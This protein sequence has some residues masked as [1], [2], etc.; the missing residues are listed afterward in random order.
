MTQQSS[1]LSFVHINRKVLH[2]DLL[3]TP[4]NENFP[5]VLNLHCRPVFVAVVTIFLHD[6][7]INFLHV[8]W[9]C[10]LFF[11]SCSFFVII[12]TSLLTTTPKPGQAGKV[13]RPLGSKLSGHNLIQIEGCKQIDRSIDQEDKPECLQFDRITEALFGDLTEVVQGDTLTGALIGG[14]HRKS[15]V[16][17]KGRHDDGQYDPA[18]C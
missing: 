15:P 2:S 11:S 12:N 13:P 14:K 18:S 7:L 17:S 5:Q 8:G 4:A 3:A 6:A 10:S 9:V 1:H 16:K